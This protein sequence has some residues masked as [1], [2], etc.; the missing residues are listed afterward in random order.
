MGILNYTVRLYKSDAMN[1]N[2]NNNNN[3]KCEGRH[4]CFCKGTP[5]K[6]VEDKV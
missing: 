4:T 2:N 5:L 6:Q 1:N 3:T